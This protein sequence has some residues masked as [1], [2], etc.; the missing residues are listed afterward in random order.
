MK[1]E[2]PN[3][4]ETVSFRKVIERKSGK[5]EKLLMMKISLKMNW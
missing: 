3:K 5:E 2:K 1:L 4:E